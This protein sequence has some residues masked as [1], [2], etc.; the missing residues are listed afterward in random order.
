MIER[1]PDMLIGAG[2][3][4]AI[5]VIREIV[6]AFLKKRNGKSAGDQDPEFWKL[7]QRRAMT[8]TLT[9]I[10][11]PI[12][13]NQ[14]IILGEMRNSLGEISTNMAVMMDRVGR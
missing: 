1:A 12:L 4:F 9:T 3:V 5:A 6:M 2:G 11:V 10:V 14:T 7:E 13:A 8:E